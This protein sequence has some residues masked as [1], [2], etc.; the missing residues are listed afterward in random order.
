MPK[1]LLHTV[2]DWES[3]QGDFALTLQDSLRDLHR[4]TGDHRRPQDHKT[5]LVIL[6]DGQELNRGV[7]VERIR[8]FTGAEDDLEE[9]FP[10]VTPKR[11]YIFW[12]PIPTGQFMVT[13]WPMQLDRKVRLH[14]VHVFALPHQGLPGGG[15]PGRGGHREGL[16][17]SGVGGQGAHVRGEEAHAQDRHVQALP[18]CQTRTRTTRTT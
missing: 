6:G 3:T 17:S 5:V 9:W 4:T 12:N 16:G 10:R 7:W 18:G 8:A 14:S 11:K 15:V 13:D 2:D 1:L